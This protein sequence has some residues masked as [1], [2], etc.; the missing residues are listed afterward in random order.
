MTLRHPV[1]IKAK[2]DLLSD[3]EVCIIWVYIYNSFQTNA[4][5][6]IFVNMFFFP[7]LIHDWRSDSEVCIT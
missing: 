5:A 7:R 6:T 2:H 3:S 1:I 4:H